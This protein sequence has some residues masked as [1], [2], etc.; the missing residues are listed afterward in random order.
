MSKRNGP[1]GMCVVWL[2]GSVRVEKGWGMLRGMFAHITR[3]GDISL[4]SKG[5]KLRLSGVY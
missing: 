1:G 2:V 4:Y 3:F 5:E